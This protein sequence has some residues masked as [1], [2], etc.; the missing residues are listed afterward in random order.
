MYKKV[1]I[2]G[3]FDRLHDGHSS[4]IRQAK[5]LG[6]EGSELVAVVARDSSVCELKGRAPQQPEHERRA[7]LAMVPEISRAVL[8]DAEL[9]SYA[10]LAAHK[11]DIICLGYD[12]RILADDLRKRMQSGIIPSVPVRILAPHEPH[13]LHS[14]L[15]ME[16]K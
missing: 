6:G 1:L 15:L 14:S 13:C 8:G 16:A 5:E 7:A 2:F 11:P 12:Q 3:V 9:G 4:F 10:V